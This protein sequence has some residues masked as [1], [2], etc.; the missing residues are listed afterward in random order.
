[1]SGRRFWLDQRRRLRNPALFDLAID[2][3]LRGC[4]VV[5]FRIGDAVS[6]GRVRDRAIVVQQKTDRPVQFELMDATQ[7]TMRAWLDGAAAR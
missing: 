3:K 2:S 5:G 4:D 7:K 1:M 6:G